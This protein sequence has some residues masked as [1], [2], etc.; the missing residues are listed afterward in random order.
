M[1][2]KSLFIKLILKYIKN[3]DSGVCDDCTD[4]YPC[5]IWSVLTCWE[6]NPE[7][8]K[9]N[10]GSI[11]CVNPGKIG[12]PQGLLDTSNNDDK[13]IMLNELEKNEQKWNALINIMGNEYTFIQRNIGF[14]DEC[15]TQDMMINIEHNEIISVQFVD[16]DALGKFCGDDIISYDNALNP[17]YYKTMDKIFDE[18]R[19]N[20]NEYNKIRIE[21]NERGYI[22]MIDAD[23]VLNAADDEYALKI[24]CL[25]F[26]DDNVQCN[27]QDEQATC[28]KECS[29]LTKGKPCMD[30]N[31]GNNIC[32]DY[33]K[34]GG[35]PSGTTDCIGVDNPCDYCRYESHPCLHNNWIHGDYSCLPLNDL[36]ECSP[37]STLCS[38]TNNSAHNNN[39]NN[40]LSIASDNI[41]SLISIT[42]IIS[43]MVYVI[44]ALCFI[45][46]MYLL[47]MFGGCLIKNSNNKI[48]YKE[49]NA[50]DVEESRGI[51]Q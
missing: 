5:A 31:A 21:Y 15:L 38:N 50:F 29:K 48:E 20:I 6:L 49:I 8:G 40:D 22:D 42:I 47:F 28:N 37:G 3:A 2:V 24:K 39:N 41:Y 7:T 25:S 35:C 18:M 44:G 32:Y 17:R 16:T 1:S 36:R 4:Q 26:P 30:N 13:E 33:M 27:K 43:I 45:S 46:L 10:P 14:R 9:C 23:P 34:Y 51:L 19:D 12:E 11:L